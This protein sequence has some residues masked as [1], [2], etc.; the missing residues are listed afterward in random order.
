M[1]TEEP[2]DVGV[3]HWEDLEL[4]SRLEETFPNHV[5]EDKEIIQ[6]KAWKEVEI[7]R[8]IGDFSTI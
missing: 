7:P 6:S 1:G 8:P 4:D 5:Q 3:E 2:Q